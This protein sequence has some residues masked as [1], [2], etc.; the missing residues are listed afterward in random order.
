M[1][2]R[3]KTA[4]RVRSAR[5]RVRRLSLLGFFR[6]RVTLTGDGGAAAA[7][8]EICRRYA[9]VYGTCGLDT[10]GRLLLSASYGT[11]T[12]L[13]RIA[14]RY[15]IVLTVLRSEGYREVLRFLMRRP[16]IPIGIVLS[17]LLAF[18]ASTHLW[19]IR[20]SGNTA[21]SS[22]EIVQA[23]SAAG[24]SCGDR[25]SEIDADAIEN[26]FLMQ[27][28]SV[29]WIA[30]NLVG[31]VAEVE[32]REKLPARAEEDTSPANLVARCDGVVT[33]CEVK[34]GNLLVKV[35][36]PVRAGEVLVSGLYDSATL[37]Y[38]YT[39]ARGEIYAETEHTLEI[40]VPYEQERTVLSGELGR[41]YTLCFF[42]QSI[43]LFSLGAAA[44]DGEW[45]ERRSDLTVF[46]KVL[47]IGL[48]T[49]TQYG[50]ETV[51][52]RYTEERAMEIAY[53]RL[54]REILA[55]PGIRDLLS[56]SVT[57]ELTDDAYVLR[58]TVRCIENIAETKNIEIEL[59]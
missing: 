29:S 33:A 5:G 34:A 6:G 51:R 32:I 50:T 11:A 27:S 12:R 2:C 43:P 15:G 47:P 3:E 25:I 39:R 17:L 20:V 4:D 48:V 41:R 31:T 1:R 55:I 13:V 46:G 30:V 45:V 16:G 54:S 10:E 59:S 44:S 9:L 21:L 35:G 42:G 36:M 38:R 37:G 58:C 53:Y 57:A 26:R 52:D 49:E 24:L 8:L 40:R 56:K 19:E 18:V 28:D 22:G 23:L 14:A 7:V